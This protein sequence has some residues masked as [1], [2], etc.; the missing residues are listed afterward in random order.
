MRQ[1][2][3]LWAA[4]EDRQLIFFVRIFFIKE[5]LAFKVIEI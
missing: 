3:T 4:I 5:H 2:V 1:S